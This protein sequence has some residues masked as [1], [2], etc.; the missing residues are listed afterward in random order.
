[1]HNLLTEHNWEGAALRKIVLGA[2][3]PFGAGE[4]SR[5]AIE[6]P[7]VRLRPRAALSLGMAVH[8][9]AT[10][11]AKYG[12]LANGTGRI[13]IKWKVERSSGADRLRLRWTE[14]GGPPVQKPQRKGFGS[15]MIERGLTHDLGGEVQLLY[16][17]AG[18]VCGINLG[19]AGR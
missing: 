7:D 14:S 12:A 16:E 10:N 4:S 3:A 1:V 19:L 5:F 15:L 18:V 13:C 11:A 6:G 17:P 2:L 8:E 9:L